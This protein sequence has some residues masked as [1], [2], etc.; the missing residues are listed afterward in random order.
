MLS[1]MDDV[2]LSHVRDPRNILA[3]RG[4]LDYSFFQK[5]NDGTLLL[6]G[7]I[8]FNSSP[9]I[10]GKREGFYLFE[11][12]GRKSVGH[13]TNGK[14]S[15]QWTL[16]DFKNGECQKANEGCYDNGKEERSY[17]H[18]EKGLWTVWEDGEIHSETHYSQGMLNGR[19]TGYVDLQKDC[20]GHFVNDKEE[21]LWSDSD[22]LL[23]HIGMNTG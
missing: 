3:F 1:K 22:N 5:V 8:S 17:E 2:I 12:L 16:F 21:G 15:G 4:K 11:P 19:H 23:S 20:E 6:F 7:E 9:F 14:K 10:N 13:Y 18:S